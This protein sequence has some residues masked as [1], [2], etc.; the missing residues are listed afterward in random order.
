MLAIRDR[1][2][3]LLASV[4]ALSSPGVALAQ[5]T[6]SATAQEVEASDTEI[7]VT[8]RKREESLQDVPVSVQA[9]G[10]EALAQA[11]IKD[12]AEIAYR[13]PGLKLSAER[14]VD[15]ELFI[16]G[17]G[18]DIQ[19]AGADGAVGIFIDGVYMP[20]GT[21]SLV[22]LYDLERV[23]VLKGPQALRFGKSVVGGLVHYIT[24]KPTD[25]LEGSVEASYGNYNKVDLAAAVRGPISETLGFGLVA[26]SR[27]H[28]GYA[29]NT[30][31]GDE[32]DQNA[33]ALRGQLRWQPDPT[34]DI[35]I[36]ADY[37]RQ[38]NGARWVD[39]LVPRDSN[40][41]T[42]NSFFA[43]PIP[44]LPGFVLPN[45]NAPF[46]SDDPR[47]G[48]H[49]FTGFQNADM[50]GISAT[51][52]WEASES[53][54]IV[55]QTAYRDSSLEAREDGGGLFYNFPIDPA[56]GAPDVTSAMLAGLDTYLA[57]VPD[58]YF[59]SGKAEDVEAFSQEL[60]MILD[61]DGPLRLEGGVYYL[62]ENIRRGE[63]VNFLFPDFQA[64]TEF[65]FAL[66]FGGTPATPQGGSNHTVT[67]SRNDNI[68]I[69][70]EVSYELTD[71]LTLDA[72]LRYAYDKK[73]YTNTR[74][75]FSFE[76]TP[77]NFVVGDTQ[78]WDAWL[79]SVT[80]RFEANRDVTLY[81]RYAKGYKPGGWTGEDAN[82]PAE[83][84]VSF[85][86]ETADSYELGAKFALAD[87]RVFVNAAAYYTNYD[88]LQTNQFLSPGPGLPPDNFVFNAVNGTRAYGLEVD[89]L[90]RLTDAF[91]I[92]GN[93]AYSKCNFTGTLII[94]DDGTDL[95]GNTCRRTPK[96]AFNVAADL[97]Q[98]IGGNLLL[99]AG[100][101]FQYTGENFYDN[102]NTPILKFDEEIML[103]ARIGV[104]D[105]DRN[106]ELTAWVKN[107]TDELNFTS[108]LDLFGTIY[109]TYI[110]PRTYGVT[111][112]YNF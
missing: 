1:R 66:A 48:A 30:R 56:S 89:F 91:S 22:D 54:T 72:G 34:L 101:N 40:E 87:R 36:A 75:G 81:A 28:D 108:K 43:P 15:T 96:H 9:F 33:Q 49:N 68:G 7:V 60:R 4:T 84:L 16:R 38:R 63:D 55:S 93:Y 18:S 85:E 25:I 70:G 77:V 86:P 37:T 10:S 103:N 20:R 106:W 6:S 99:L 21:G 52:D 45:R 64:I 74:S 12:F 57:T 8:A 50:Y 100:T 102:P 3:T 39:L 95:D 94:D 107:L 13:V 97:E 41:V 110:P 51:A 44:S 79:P 76:G 27:T 104:S 23:E 46:Q 88:N 112:K 42:F 32:E 14:A 109:G 47:R 26:S 98:P 19:G 29:I 69:F 80:L 65:A 105:A 92:S 71:R 83:A 67:T 24:K 17:I 90:A 62:H 11:G 59:D 5:T 78:S 73:K 111:A 31:G 58:T 2:W 53:L 82:T 61:N 35:N